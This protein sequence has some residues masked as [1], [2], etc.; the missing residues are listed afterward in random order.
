MIL[1][2]NDFLFFVVKCKNFYYNVVTNYNLVC[3]IVISLK[4]SKIHIIIRQ[5]GKEN[6]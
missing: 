4:S 2:F 6:V 1:Y 5:G 3:A